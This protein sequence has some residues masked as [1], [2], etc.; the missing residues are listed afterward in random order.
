MTEVFVK[1]NKTSTKLMEI[2]MILVVL[3]EYEWE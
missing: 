1:G 2:I 3:D